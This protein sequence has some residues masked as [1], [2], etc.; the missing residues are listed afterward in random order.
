MTNEK[1]SIN[2]KFRKNLKGKMI[3]YSTI[4]LADALQSY[5]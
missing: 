5:F 2:R 1:S 4:K 3:Y